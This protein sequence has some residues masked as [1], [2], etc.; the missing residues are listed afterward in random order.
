MASC[1]RGYH[2]YSKTWT[3][4][5]R[6]ELCCERELSNVIDCYTVAVKKDSRETVGHLPKKILQMCSMSIQRGEIT[7]TVTGVEDILQILCKVG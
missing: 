4:A 2:V 3:A 1:V 5:L 6:E 7:G